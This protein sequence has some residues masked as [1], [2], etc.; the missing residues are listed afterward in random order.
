MLLSRFYPPRVAGHSLVF[1]C[2][3]CALHAFR[4][5]RDLDILDSSSIVTVPRKN[6]KKRHKSQMVLIRLQYPR[7]ELS[8]SLSTF[9]S[10]SLFAS[11][12]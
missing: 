7:D 6:K 5:D 10:V 12:E 9:D 11:T 4:V 2:G 1:T 3:C 8:E